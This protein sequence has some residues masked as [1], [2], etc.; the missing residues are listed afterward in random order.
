MII[1]PV[2]MKIS[3]FPPAALSTMRSTMRRLSSRMRNLAL[4][5]VFVRVNSLT[6]ISIPMKTT[7]VPLSL[8]SR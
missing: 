3:S 6:A 8:V 5:T 2:L 4:S 1:E 7:L